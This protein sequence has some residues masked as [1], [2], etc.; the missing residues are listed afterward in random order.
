MIICKD[1]NKNII[2][3]SL[4]EWKKLCPPEG[5][6]RQWQDGRSAKELAK[7]WINNKGQYLEILLG[8]FDE[9]KGINFEIV[10]PE[11]ESKFDEYKG[12]GRQHDLLILANDNSGQVL[13]S[14]EAKVDEQ[15]GERIKDYYLQKIT[16]RINGIPTNAPDRIEGLLHSIFGANFDKRVFNLRYQLLHSIAGTVAEAKKREVKKA[17][18]VI[19]TFRSKDDNKF[20]HN[21]HQRN[22]RDLDEFIKQLSNNKMIEIKNNNLI[23]PFNTMDSDYFSSN[24][25]LY[26][27]K[28]EVLVD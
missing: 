6:D 4:D 26:V 17:V 23:G 2:I 19:N 8:A 7:E 24:I 9:F 5:K 11:F 22:M 3:N 16:D 14:V 12:K 13:I 25:K 21:K 1:L 20:N 10:S 28:T 18:L 27:I 15:F